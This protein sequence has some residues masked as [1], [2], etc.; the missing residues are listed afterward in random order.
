MGGIGLRREI[1]AFSLLGI[2]DG[3]DIWVMSFISVQ[4]C[5]E[6]IYIF[7]VTLTLSIISSRR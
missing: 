7:T 3:V 4:A 5:D 6:I 1:T 2:W